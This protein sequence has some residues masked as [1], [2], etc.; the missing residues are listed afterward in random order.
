MTRGA[1]TIYFSLK[2]GQ[3]DRKRHKKRPKNDFSVKPKNPFFSVLE[4]GL[5]LKCKVAS[6]KTVAIT[7]RTDRQ[8]SR[9]AK[10]GK[11][12]NLRSDYG[13]SIYT[14]SIPQEVSSF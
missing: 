3:K 10:E 8:T 11:Q 12:S 9:R 6:S 1:F 4:W 7:A 13:V 2:K 14:P 5:N